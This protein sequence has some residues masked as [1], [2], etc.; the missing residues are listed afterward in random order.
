MHKPTSNFQNLN[1]Y[2]EQ[3]QHDSILE[4]TTFLYTSEVLSPL[5]Q[6]QVYARC[7]KKAQGLCSLCKLQ[8][9]YKIKRQTI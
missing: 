5:A 4:S 2:F 6:Q 7:V 3:L 1:N 9:S 8:L